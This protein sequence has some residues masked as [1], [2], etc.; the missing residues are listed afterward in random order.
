M[1][2]G[3]STF[4]ISWMHHY[5]VC[6]SWYSLLLR[7]SRLCILLELKC[8][9]YHLQSTWVTSSS[10]LRGQWQ[11]LRRM[12]QLSLSADVAPRRNSRL[13]PASL[14][15]NVSVQNTL[16]SFPAE[17]ELRYHPRL[18][19][20]TP[21]YGH[22]VRKARWSFYPD[23]ERQQH[24][25]QIGLSGFII[26]WC[27]Y[28]FWWRR[29]SIILVFPFLAPPHNGIPCKWRGNPGLLCL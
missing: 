7:A 23:L 1:V 11:C 17:P 24:L 29:S 25:R 27:S 10:L 20:V 16:Q 8:G 2:A 4:L 15:C 13:T 22:T 26:K 21:P 3:V 6:C 18:P 28:H 12:M 19:L 14:P 5:T 9:L